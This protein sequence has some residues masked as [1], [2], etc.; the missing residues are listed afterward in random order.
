[1]WVNQQHPDMLITLGKRGFRIA[2][3]LYKKKSVVIGALP[4]KPNG[5]SGISLSADPT[6]LFQSLNNLAPNISKVHVVYSSA[7]NW[8]IDL[9]SDQAQQYGLRINKLEVKNIKQ[10]LASYEQ[11]LNHI[12]STTDAIWLPADKITTHDQV[13]L[14]TLLASSWEHNL[15]LFSSTSTHSKRGALFSVV[16]DYHALGKQL[17]TMV[18]QIHSSDQK[19]SVIP[20]QHLKLAVN[21]R[22]ASHLG[23]NYPAQQKTQFHLTYPQ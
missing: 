10:A 4:I 6:F 19:T 17:V 9:A 21:L 2:K 14:P 12:D 15:V 1:M 3:R 18:K 22:T 11:L 20:L 5:V 13:I 16:P 8:L 23:Y 7:S